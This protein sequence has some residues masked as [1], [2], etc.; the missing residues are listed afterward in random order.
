[1]KYAFSNIAWPQVE[2]TLVLSMLARNGITGIE[3]APTK[4]WPEWDGATPLAARRCAGRLLDD[5]FVIPAL[6]A[7]LFGRPDAQLFG[8]RG[9]SAFIDHLTR[10][11]DLAH[12]F[13]AP[14]V[15]LGAPR[16]RDRGSLSHP[17]AMDAAA[18]VFRTL[19]ERYRERDTC[20]CIEPNPQRYNCNFVFNVTQGR[21]LVQRVAHPGFGLHLDAAAMH[22]E[23]DELATHWPDVGSI[24]RHYH[25][26]EPDLGDFRHPEVPHA[27]NL[28]FLE[29][30]GFEGWCSVEMREPAVPLLNAGPWS[31]LNRP[32]FLPTGTFR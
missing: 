27:T 14:V 4:L 18:V 2:E 10:V 17:D 6:Q 9:P 25:I 1:M 26:S 23:G 13:R 29:T 3:I 32:R 31:L 24:A 11:A 12:A 28:A 19:A 21:E 5:G 20:L 16:Q 8:S 22:L 15:V 30:A 7:V